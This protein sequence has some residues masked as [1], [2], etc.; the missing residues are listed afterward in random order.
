[1]KDCPEILFVLGNEKILNY[2]SIS[3]VGT[4]N[5]S[6]EGNHIAF[7]IATNLAKEKIIIISGLANGIDTSAHLGAISNGKT[8][9]I[10][11]CGFQFIS[12]KQFT[13][14]NQILLT[15]GAIISEYFPDA[16]PQTFSFLKRNRL[17]AAI[18]K[19]LIV[20]EAPEK[21]GALNTAKIAM[22]L[23]RPV[24]AIPWSITTFRGV[25]SNKLLENGAH[26]LTNFTQV[27]TFFSVSNSTS[28]PLLS[29]NVG[30]K[31]QKKTEEKIANEF[32]PLHQYIKQNQPILKEKIYSHFLKE[33][34]A[35][36]N[37]KLILMEL[38]NLI[39]K[40]DEFYFIK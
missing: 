16:P 39:Y 38:N 3:I 8:I 10:I 27:L 25:G 7:D 35:S 36:L 23:T 2:F 6:K 18:S 9:A 22:Q 29:N 28:S 20:I 33:S 13:I 1:L 24:F 14:L 26:I 12:S 32:K 31:P 37:S 15:G 5:S 30:L 40:Q 21:S 11:A 4:R 19:A 17:I 34:I